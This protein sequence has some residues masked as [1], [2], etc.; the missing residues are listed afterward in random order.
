MCLCALT[1]TQTQNNTH[2][3]TQ[4]HGNGN[5]CIK[6]RASL[7]YA[8]QNTGQILRRREVIRMITALMFAWSDTGIKQFFT[9]TSD[10]E[11]TIMLM[12]DMFVWWIIFK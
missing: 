12:A 5:P 4:A 2:N 9:Q 10:L 3:K 8:T 6:A 1:H 7:P 11:L